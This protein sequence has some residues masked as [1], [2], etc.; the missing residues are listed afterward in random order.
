MVIAGQPFLA[1]DEVVAS[2][3]GPAGTPARE[4]P[5]GLTY[6]RDVYSLSHVALPFPVSDGLYGTQPDPQDDF[7]IRL[8]TI[9]ARGETGVLVVDAGTLMRMMSNPFYPYVAARITAVAGR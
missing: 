1:Y 3:A 5:L 7:G 2:I 6:P 9:A 8:G 4:E